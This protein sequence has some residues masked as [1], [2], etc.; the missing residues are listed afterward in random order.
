MSAT[1]YGV[2][3]AALDDLPDPEVLASGEL[4]VAYALGR[5]LL[6]PAGALEEIGDTAPY[7]SLDLRDWL[8]KRMSE[9]DRADLEAQVVHVLSQ[10]E[11]V[12]TVAATVT[13]TAGAGTTR[14]ITVAVEVEG[15]D[16]P[17]SFVLSVD[18]VTATLLRGN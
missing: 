4:N 3:V 8:G 7:D 2:D 16:G 17:F 18:G 11:R 14:K 10:D 5:R 12:L 6:Q 15:T 1:D 9:A 13:L